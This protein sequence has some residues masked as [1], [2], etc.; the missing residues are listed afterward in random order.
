MSFLPCL[1]TFVDTTNHHQGNGVEQ[2]AIQKIFLEYATVQDA[3]NAEK[4]LKGRKFGPN[5]VE[6]SYFIE[7]D[8][9]AGKLK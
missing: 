7:G 1:L 2:S 5:L 6:T 4:E 8:Y 3:S 9:Q